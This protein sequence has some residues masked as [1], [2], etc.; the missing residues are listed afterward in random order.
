MPTAPK[1]TEATAKSLE[2]H[3]VF[4]K[5]TTHAMRFQQ[6]EPEDGSRPEV[7]TLYITQQ[8]WK[9]LDKPSTLDVTIVAGA[10]E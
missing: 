8:A 7:G 1:K 9:D 10:K 3:F 4:V 5:A 2:L 6:D